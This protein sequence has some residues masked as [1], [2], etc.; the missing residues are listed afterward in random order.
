MEQEQSKVMLVTD[1]EQIAR[2]LMPQPMWLV[3]PILNRKYAQQR[4]TMTAE[5]VD[6]STLN[7]ATMSTF[8]VI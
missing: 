1:L 8:E 5:I 4:M 7:L 2:E 3:R 6:L